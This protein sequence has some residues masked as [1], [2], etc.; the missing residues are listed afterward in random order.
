MKFTPETGHCRMCHKEARATFQ[1]V[2]V[3]GDRHMHNFMT[4][5]AKDEL[6]SVILW[7]WE[8]EDLLTL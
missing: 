1:D 3:N 4:K 8:Q 2:R 5:F 6:I 7:Q